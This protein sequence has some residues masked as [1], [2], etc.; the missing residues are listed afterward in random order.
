AAS[1]TA[2]NAAQASLVASTSNALWWGKQPASGVLSN[3]S[4]TGAWT[5]NLTAGTNVVLSTNLSS[6]SI[7]Y[8]NVPLQTQLTNGIT[9][10]ATTNPLAVLY[11]NSLPALTN[12]FVSSGITN[13]LASYQSLTNYAY[14]NSN[15]S[16][17]VTASITNGLVQASVTNGLAT[18]N[19]VAQNFLT[20]A[21]VA[22]NALNSAKQ[23]ASGI[24]TNLALTG[25][26][27][28][29]I[30]S[31]LNTYLTTNTGIVSINASNQTWLTNGLVIPSTNGFVTSSITNGLASTNYVQSYSDTN[32]AAQAAFVSSTNAAQIYLSK[33]NGAAYSLAAVNQ[34]S[35]GTATNC[36]VCTNRMGVSGAGS[37]I[38]NGTYQFDPS[39]FA[40]SYTNTV[41][42]NAIIL[43]SGGSFYIQTNSVSL[44]SASSVNGAWSQ[45]SGSLPNPSCAYGSYWNMNG[46]ILTGFIT[47]TN[48]PTGGG[49]SGTTNF[50]LTGVVQSWTTNNQFST[51]GSNV[52]INLIA[53]YA[54]SPTNGISSSTASNIVLNYGGTLFDPLNAALN[55]TNTAFAKLI[56]TNAW[57][58]LTNGLTAGNMPPSLTNLP[59]SGGGSGIPTLN[60]SGT[61]TTLV[62]AKSVAATN[63]TAYGTAWLNNS[64]LV[65]YADSSTTSSNQLVQSFSTNNFFTLSNSVVGAVFE[66][67]TNGDTV[68]ITSLGFFNY[69]W[70]NSPVSYEM[71]L[72]AGNS[73][74]NVLILKTNITF[75]PLNSGTYCYTNIIP[76]T[77]APGS[78]YTMWLNAPSTNTFIVTSGNPINSYFLNVG[79]AAGYGGSTNYYNAGS[80]QY[81][82]PNFLFS[83]KR[84]INTLSNSF[85]LEVI[86]TNG[87]GIN[88]N[89][90]AGFT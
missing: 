40:N 7:V 28:N 57:N 80:S 74:T 79:S 62:T 6:P 83:V 73:A 19:W 37:G 69:S 20:N 39:G 12:G 64:N 21:A 68:T 36:L 29:P 66:T 90:S 10:L 48:L 24:L 86:S 34:F 15:P 59:S 58:T 51:S 25:A 8:V 31:G 23:P 72:F 30:A 60:G 4:L 14:P 35:I 33:T 43:I 75:G 84:P 32:G 2:S 5:N 52:I 63:L 41:N 81:G 55:A 9:S 53:Q 61:N 54:S 65:I 87:I 76:T 45:V 11:T 50:T 88:T 78:F 17:F 22:S 82:P 26:Y 27:T 85:L 67:P 56:G 77:L 18:T 44:Y 16:N 49:G 46:T 42:P 3:L 38:V 71:D 47:G 13:G 89:I 70:T 1:Q